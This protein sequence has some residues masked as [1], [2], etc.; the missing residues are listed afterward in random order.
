MTIRCIDPEN[1]AVVEI[2]SVDILRGGGGI[3]NRQEILGKYLGESTWICLQMCA[4][5]RCATTSA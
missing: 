3:T 5:S 4:T 1:D 2:A